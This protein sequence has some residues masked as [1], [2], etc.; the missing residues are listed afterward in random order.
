MCR[1]SKKT[2]L[3]EDRW[4]Q[5]HEKMLNIPDFLRNMIET[6]MRYNTN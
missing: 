6:K 4:L 1:R 3:Q 2:V 5:A